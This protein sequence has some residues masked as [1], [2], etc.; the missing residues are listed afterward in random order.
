VRTL[1]YRTEM[2]IGSAPEDVFDFCSDLRSELRW[3]PKVKYVKKLTDG[4]VGVGTRYRAPWANSGP[5]AVQVT[6]FD[7]PRIWETNAKARAMGIRF[8]GTVAD[9]APGARYTAKLELQPK[10]LAWLVAPLALLAMRRQDQ[11]NMRRIREALESTTA[12]GKEAP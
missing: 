2:A 9:A 6:H 10:G 4:P 8:Q 7:R 12:E 3:N 11:K 1:S 5:T